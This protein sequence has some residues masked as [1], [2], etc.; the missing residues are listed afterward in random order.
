MAEM[1]VDMSR[2][3]THRHLVSWVGLAPGNVNRGAPPKAILRCVLP[4]YRR[5]RAPKT[6]ICPL[7]IVGWP[8]DGARNAPWWQWLIPF[9]QQPIKWPVTDIPIKIRSATLSIS[10]R[11]TTLSLGSRI[12]SKSWGTTLRLP[13]KLPKRQNSHAVR[14]KPKRYFL[15]S[16]FL[17]I[18]RDAEY[19]YP[20]V[21]H[22]PAETPVGV[23]QCESSTA[24]CR[25]RESESKRDGSARFMSCS[26]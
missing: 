14:P 22:E 1:G 11:N 24:C 6:R 12:A 10:A 19:M 23:I 17:K 3:S 20:L 4:S 5:P 7:S 25:E 8:H 15:S 13:H 26:Q 18:Q 2:F 16:S 9:S 21:S